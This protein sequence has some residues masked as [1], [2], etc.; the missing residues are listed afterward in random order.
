MKQ[1]VRRQ[2]DQAATRYHAAA[3]VQREVAQQLIEFLPVNAGARVLEVGS[4]SG[5]LTQLLLQQYM[6]LRVDAVDISPQ[7]IHQAQVQ[8]GN[9]SRLRFFES[10]IMQF[11]QGHLYDGIVSSAALQWLVPFES[12]LTHLRSM[13]AARGWLSFA[14]MT[15]GT[16]SLLHQLRGE[17]FPEKSAAR[18]L[19][20]VEQVE[21]GV[22]KS[23]LRN[24]RLETKHYFQ[25]I[26]QASNVLAQIKEIGVTAGQAQRR[27]FLTRSE[28]TTLQQQYKRRCVE[29]FGKLGVQYEVVYC[30]CRKS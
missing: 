18:R 21:R 15:S 5:F 1:A 12:G 24:V 19:P 29:R 6:E 20:T 14:L 9:N 28:L 25:E 8:L 10:D 22:A 27:S 17:L 16:L 11:K 2:F 7:M 23:S 13:L 3:T 30:S 26:D 4:G